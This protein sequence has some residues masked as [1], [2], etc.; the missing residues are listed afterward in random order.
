MILTSPAHLLKIEGA[1]VLTSALLLYWEQGNSWLLFV[2]LLF[3]PDLSMIGYLS[4]SRLGA[5]TYNLFHTVTLPVVAAVVGLLVD[6]GWAVSVGLTWLAHI[7]L[8]R[9]IG[10]GLKY[11]ESFKETH[12][13]RV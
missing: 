12:L 9:L 10:Y 6:Q 5:A 3:A 13:A 4:G 2:L 11:P 7:G 1:A 8:D